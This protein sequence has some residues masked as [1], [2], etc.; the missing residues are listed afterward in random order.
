MTGADHQVIEL[1]ISGISDAVEIGAGGFGVVYRAVEADLGRTVAVKVLSGNL[2]EAARLRFERERRAM[3]TLSGHP[4]IVTI[5]RGGYNATGKAY[6][7]MEYLARGSLADQ[8]QSDGPLAWAEVLKFGIQ[9]SGALETSHRAGVLHRDIKPGNILLSGLSNAKLCDFGIARLHGAPETQSSVVTASIAHAP[10]E[11]INGKRPNAVA[12]VYSLASTMFELVSGSPP[13]VRPTDESMVPILARIH[14][15][16]IPTLPE[17]QLPAP[18]GAAIEAATA[19]DPTTRPNSALAFG[20]LLVEVQQQLAQPATALPFAPSSRPDSK[21]PADIPPFPGATQDPLP[22]PAAYSAEPVAEATRASSGQPLASADPNRVSDGPP[23]ATQASGGVQP[24]TA[25]GAHGPDQPGATQGNSL[26]TPIGAGPQLDGVPR[27]PTSRQS[28]SAGPDWSRLAPVAA[29]SA[30]LAVA[31]I[32]W[33]LIGD[34]GDGLRETETGGTAE[35][36]NTDDSIE[37][38]P[39]ETEATEAEQ[40]TTSEGQSENDYPFYMDVTDASGS[41]HL[42]VPT[43]WNDTDGHLG[44]NDQPFLGAAPIL[45]GAVGMI[46]SFD[47]PGVTV[48]IELANADL[49]AVLDDITEADCRSTDRRDLEVPYEGR[50]E[51]LTNCLDTDTRLVHYVFTPPFT[52]VMAIMRIQIVSERDLIAAATISDSLIIGSTS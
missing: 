27:R 9:V 38:A 34:E 51:L 42:K 19:K 35:V 47:S 29:I 12:D 20:Q 1:G 23:D 2:D 49:D 13:F 32:A 25:T 52:T 46:G 10:P 15:D 30:L 45:Y 3:G 39:T 17:E 18:L 7:V 43:E 40:A 36:T 48:S 28:S 4:N 33:L 24:P 41:I 11:I 14:T 6:L 26:D 16:P 22:A 21:P 31:L 5:Y 44:T 37:V 8:L 50:F